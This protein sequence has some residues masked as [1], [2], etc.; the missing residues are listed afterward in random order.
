M[1]LQLPQDASLLKACGLSTL[2]KMRLQRTN[3][4]AFAE[5]KGTAVV[6]VVAADATV[7]LQA[8]TPAVSPVILLLLVHS[9][10]VKAEGI[11]CCCSSLVL[12]LLLLLLLLPHNSLLT[13]SRG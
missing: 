5:L 11:C 9:W 4:G 8:Y 13:G 1:L 3:P 2:R 10:V 12:G 7:L 6:A